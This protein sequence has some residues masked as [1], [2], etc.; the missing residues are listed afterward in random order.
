MRQESGNFQDG[1]HAGNERGDERA[2][3]DVALPLPI[4]RTFTYA[5]EGEPPAPGTRVR[6]PFQRQERIGWVVGPAPDGPAEPHA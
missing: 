2:R 6:V 4:H 5:C 3:V 1:Q